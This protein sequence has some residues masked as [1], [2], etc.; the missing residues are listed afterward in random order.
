MNFQSLFIRISLI[1]LLATPLYCLATDVP[2]RVHII[3]KETRAPIPGYGVTVT[4]GHIGNDYP[5]KLEPLLSLGVTD[6][7]GNLTATAPLEMA[8]FTVHADKWDSTFLLVFDHC[9]YGQFSAPVPAFAGVQE[10][11][12]SM[13][14]FYELKV[15]TD[16]TKSFIKLDW[17]LHNSSPL[18]YLPYPGVM[19]GG[20]LAINRSVD[21]DQHGLI[22]I[23]D[24]PYTADDEAGS[25]IDTDVDPNGNHVYHY[26]LNPTKYFMSG[27]WPSAT[28]TLNSS[29]PAST[30]ILPKPVP[31]VSHCIVLAAEQGAYQNLEVFPIPYED[32]ITVKP[33]QKIGRT[34]SVTVFS[35]LGQPLYSIQNPVVSNGMLILD[36]SVLP[37]GVQI[38]ELRTKSLQQVIRISKVR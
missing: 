6:D 31:D 3:D 5:P 11:E 9:V 28:V 23:Y 1:L 15:S 8:H 34:F 38:L 10:Y 19:A 13:P 16:D 4:T 25:F 35:I 14:F 37:A 22:T 26:S 33:D 32:R 7:C 20:Q 17:K 2:I 18:I 12:V 27:C 30:V 24:Q 29:T 36:L 21:G